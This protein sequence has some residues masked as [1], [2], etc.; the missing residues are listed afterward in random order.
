MDYSFTAKVEKEFDEIAEGDIVWNE[1][2]NS[3]YQPFHSKI[4]MR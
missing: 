2:I 1:M 3:F 4:E